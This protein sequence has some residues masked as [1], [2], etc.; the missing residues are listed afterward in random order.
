MLEQTES[1]R[2]AV[3]IREETGVALADGGYCSEENFTKRSAGDVELLVAVQKDYKQRKAMQDQPPPQEPLPDGL[4]PMESME[5]KLL[6]ERAASCISCEAR[7]LSRC[8]DRSKMFVELT[9]FCGE[10]S[11]HVAASGR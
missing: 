9:D 10:D 8:L 6:T 5:Q 4:S 11:K 3:G 1:N 2:K 7:W